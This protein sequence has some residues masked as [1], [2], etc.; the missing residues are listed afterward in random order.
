MAL[1][2]RLGAEPGVQRVDARLI[3][4]I[5]QIDAVDGENLCATRETRR[6]HCGRGPGLGVRHHDVARWYAG[7]DL[8]SRAVAGLYA[9][10]RQRLPSSRGI[11][12]MES[13]F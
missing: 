2:S 1:S 12:E 8:E 13:I 6:E 7:D 3:A 5:D 11:R 10:L 4:C 9:R